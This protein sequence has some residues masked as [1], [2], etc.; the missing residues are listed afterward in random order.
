MMK[1]QRR[2]IDRLT[3]QLRQ[4]AGTLERVGLQ[5]YVAYLGKPRRMLVQNLLAGMAR[6][7]G[8]AVGFTLL[9]ALIIVIAQRL[10]QGNIPWLAGLFA[11][12]IEAVERYRR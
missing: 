9:G 5:E 1:S 3:R 4:T 6:G 10:A 12:I 11:E 7:V 8:M 2:F